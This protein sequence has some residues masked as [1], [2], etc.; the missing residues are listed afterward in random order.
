MA[1]GSAPSCRCCSLLL[2]IA[3]VEIIQS[4]RIV[5]QIVFS[6]DGERLKCGGGGCVGGAASTSTAAFRW[7]RSTLAALPVVED[8]RER[9]PAGVL[10]VGRTDR[11]AVAWLGGGNSPRPAYRRG[12]PLADARGSSTSAE[13]TVQRSRGWGVGMVSALPVIEVS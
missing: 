5:V 10:D 6:D 1:T 3:K 13:P 4:L 12:P 11:T 7:K 8:P 2:T 9:Q